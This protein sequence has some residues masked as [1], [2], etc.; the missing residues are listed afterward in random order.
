MF[1]VFLNFFFHLTLVYLH[2]YNDAEDLKLA[3]YD[4][5]KL[6]TKP[7]FPFRATTFTL[8]PSKVR[9]V[10]CSTVQCSTVCIG[11]IIMPFYLPTVIFEFLIIIFVISYCVKNYSTILFYFIYSFIHFYFYS[12]QLLNLNFFG[13]KLV[14]F[15]MDN[16]VM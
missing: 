3:F 11:V 6:D 4:P 15:S 5:K 12:S 8:D 7:S 10:Q 16:I 2:K 14:N 1:I 9:T 13:H